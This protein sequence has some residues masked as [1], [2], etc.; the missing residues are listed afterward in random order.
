MS[1]EK[2][3]SPTV[4]LDAM[5]LVNK[6]RKLARSSVSIAKGWL[7]IAA[8]LLMGMSGAAVAVTVT[9]SPTACASVAGIGTVA[10]TNPGNA[11]SSNNSYATASVDGTTTNYLQCTGYNFAIPAGATINGITVNIERKSSSTNNGGSA[12]AA[13]RLVKAGTIGATDR[14]TGTTY[15]TS[16]VIEAHGS[17]ADL[18]GTTWTVADINN[19]N[20]GAAFAAT[21]A[22][23]GGAAHTVSVD[24]IQIVVDYSLPSV[25][26][27]NLASPDPTSPATSVSWAVTFSESVTGVDATDFVLVQAGGVTSA[28]ITSVTGSGTTWTI[29]ANT[30]TGTGT[31]GLNL[32]DNDTIVNAGGAPLGGAGAGN[33][34]FTGQVYSVLTCITDTFST[35]TLD[36]S[37]WT[38]RTIAG[39]YTPAVV[40]I[41]GADN[42]LRLTDTGG[43]EATFAQLKRTFPAAGNKIVLEFDYFAYGGSGADG[44]AVTFSDAT[45]SSTTG[46]FGGSL[47]YAQ[48]TG[49]NGFGGGWLGVG[50]D[51]YGNFPNPNEGRGGY[52]GGWMAPVGA[53]TAAGFYPNNV[54]IRGSYTGVTPGATG[55]SL[56]ANTGTLA[57]AV[58]PPGGAA[59]ATPYRYRVTID[60]SNGVNA[61]VT[62][63][64]D[65]TAPLGNSY[66]TLVPTFDAKAAGS[67][68]VAVPANWL[69]S[70]TG[71]T[72]GSTN[73]HEFKQVKVCA[74]TI[75]AGGPHHL[76][77]QHGSGTGVTCT[78]STLTIR[79]CADALVPCT[80]YTAGVTG[81]LSATGTPTVNWAGGSGAFTIAAGSSTVTKDVQVTTVG[82]TVFGATSTPAASA[83]TT[84][85]FGTPGCTFTAA[86]AGFIVTAPNHIAETV[87]TLTIQAVKSVPGNPLLCAPGM[88]GA[89]TVTL[90]CSYTNP[91]S[92]TL[93]VRVGGV[94]LNAAG[95]AAAACDAG[96]RNVSLTFNGFGVATPTLQYA[97]V[98]NML[99]NASFTGTAGTIDAGLN[100]VGSGSFI[101][102]PASFAF[103]GITA[104]LIK[105]GNPFSATVTA[106]NAL[107]AATANFGKESA[108]EGVTLTSNLVSPVGGNNP[109]IGNN[110][111]FGGTFVNGVATVNNL[112]WGEVGIIT[113]TANLTSGNYLGSALTASGTDRKSVV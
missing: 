64:R 97:D 106:Q 107:G 46:G 27:I 35:G 20:F 19:A 42:R 17:A 53:N 34:N 25:S 15:T 28:A 4:K 13:M 99:I 48:R 24:H 66:T 65:F 40:N 68:Q 62:V 95:N 36:T 18:W 38:V 87:F 5:L 26:S 71:S 101:T 74:N 21:K 93:P 75:V 11:V 47:G 59:G 52:P 108:A 94:A 22:S 10:W 39:P 70:F 109:S 88:T 55:Y 41:G 6:A 54:S 33:G 79:A 100:L 16:D 73:F 89:K 44:I 51:E 111:I 105:A 104:G 14:T 110:I 67:G 60:H 77:I 84:C 45:V 8:V 56:L 58:A 72:G 30:G 82:S 37:L 78:P 96:G 81:T 76:E 103:S 98:G 102:A 113:M 90:K 12:D 3:L 49:I 50:V 112:S 85:N 91:A 7:F 61:W 57:T 32:V 31:L 2:M 92:G 23:S 1:I 86:D 69:V 63:E 43:S 29:T 80:P 9:A 83:A